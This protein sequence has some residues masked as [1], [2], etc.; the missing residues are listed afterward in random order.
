M[1]VYKT[2][3]IMSGTS[4]D[5]VDIAYVEFL[6]DEHWKFQLKQ[7][8]SVSYGN[9]WKNRL[10][11][12]SE[13]SA[14]EFAKTHV[15]YGHYLGDLTSGFIKEH[16]LDVNLI[17]SHGHTIFHQP[18]NGFTSQIGDGSAIAAETGC[19]V[20]CDFRS[21]DVSKEG[22]GAPLVPIG[23]A[24]L[25]GEYKARVNLGGFSNISIGG[26]N[27]LHAFDICPVNIVLNS[28][29]NQIG[30][31]FDKGGELARKGQIID[32]LL[33]QLNRLKYFK[34][35]P[36]KSL[37]LEW[38]QQEIFPLLSSSFK[39]EDLLKTFVEHAAIQ[40]SSTL[41]KSFQEKDSC[42]FTG[43]G[44]Y[45]SFLMERIRELSKSEII[46]PSPDIIEMKEAII[47]AFL[48]LLR[49]LGEENILASYTGASNNSISGAMYLY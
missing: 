44:S 20:V 41:N 36:P 3:G 47:F 46:I 39:E 5:G 12:L 32:E 30:K 27:N 45:N 31:D 19:P 29:C 4:L 40:I 35:N 14:F 28:I 18:D 24:L 26:L 37:G 7:F 10:Q 42:L 13:S 16:Q 38:V 21:M 15:A 22:Q 9:E 33:V 1:K 23:D 17:A 2:I 43:G 6:K 48:G 8:T 11:N 49:F 34:Q 25:F